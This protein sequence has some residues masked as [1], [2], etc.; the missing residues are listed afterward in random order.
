MRYCRIPSGGL[1]P[2]I[3]TFA[4]PSAQFTGNATNTL[5]LPLT[6]TSAA[7]IVW[8]TDAGLGGGTLTGPNTTW[9]LDWN[10]GAPSL[11]SSVYDGIY[12]V[13][14]QPYSAL[15]VPGE[16]RTITVGINRVVPLQPTGF[17][18]GRNTSRSNMVVDLQWS[19][20]Q[21]RDIIGY[22]VYRVSGTNKNQVCPSS[23]GGAVVTTL[24][25]VDT[26]PPSTGTLTY[27]LYAVDR[28]DI[29]STASIS[30]SNTRESSTPATISVPD[31]AAGP[32]APTQPAV[33]TSSGSPRLD[34]SQPGGT[35]NIRFYRI[36]RDGTA[37]TDRYASTVTNGTFFVDGNPGQ[38][39]LITHTCRPVVARRP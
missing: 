36:Y 11:S 15:G 35:S 39:T 8:T 4:Q 37:L 6:S 34:W 3:T 10:L 7:S 16:A 18:G 20:N 26:S 2:R 9:S 12:T 23:G 28:A 14:A 22:R 32:P 31:A 38:G 25:C 27:Q 30:S 24:S 29:L 13:S 5:S 19:A 17:L 21:A 33:S 1:G